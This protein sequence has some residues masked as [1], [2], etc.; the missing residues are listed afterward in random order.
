MQQCTSLLLNLFP[1]DSFYLTELNL[2]QTA[3][4]LLLPGGIHVLV[5]SCVQTGHQITSQFRPFALRQ[6]QGFLQQFTG[7]VVILRIISR[8]ATWLGQIPWAS[9]KRILAAA[10]LVWEREACPYVHLAANWICE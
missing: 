5:N 7:F 3:H 8:A 9:V 10:A 4:D 1:R 2:V 6:C